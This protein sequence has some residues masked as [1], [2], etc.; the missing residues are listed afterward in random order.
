MKKVFMLLAVFWLAAVGWSKTTTTTTNNDY[1]TTDLEFIQ[2]LSPPMSLNSY[3]IIGETT[4]AITHWASDNSS[5]VRARATEETTIDT[6][7]GIAAEKRSEQKG[8]PPI[9]LTVNLT[10]TTAMITEP[11]VQ[12]QKHFMGPGLI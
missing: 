11:A 3:N 6:P 4:T 7:A 12:T 2:D 1:A 10:L 5:L 8:N 9:L